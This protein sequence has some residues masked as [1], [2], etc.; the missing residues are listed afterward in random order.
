MMNDLT[1]QKTLGL[2]TK[3]IS[4]IES[5]SKKSSKR[6]KRYFN[7]DFE[8]NQ[9]PVPRSNEFLRKHISHKL[10]M[11]VLYADLIGSTK[12]SSKLFPDELTMIIRGYCQEMAYLIEHY[13]GNV[14]KFVGDAAIGYFVADTKP[15]LTA[16]KMIKCSISM[17]NVIE[18][19][20]NPVLK[21]KNYPE[22]KVKITADFGM[23]N[24]ILYSSNEKKAHIDIIGLAMNLA[25]KMQIFA[26]PNQIVIGKEVYTRLNSRL[27][28][29][30]KKVKADTSIWNYGDKKK[31][32]Y[33]IF[34]STK[35]WNILRK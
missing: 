5:L 25:A 13:D 10:P 32:P 31:S 17:I 14:L 8:Y 34:A 1:R 11:F 20:L 6:V 28:N 7:N 35:N 3:D 15:S 29:Y 26:K 30:F 23:G 9:L 21:E 22:L 33:S 27:K 2:D 19:A 16:D 18:N 4:E 12:L 24:I